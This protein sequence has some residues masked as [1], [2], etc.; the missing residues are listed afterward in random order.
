MKG[1]NRVMIVYKRKHVLQDILCMYMIQHL[2][3]AHAKRKTTS[4]IT[5]CRPTF[6]IE[7]SLS[8][9]LAA[10]SD[11]FSPV[12]SSLRI[13]YSRQ[14]L[15][16]RNCAGH[17]RRRMSRGYRKATLGGT[18]NSG[19]VSPTILMSSHST[20]SEQKACEQV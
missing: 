19:I 11:W 20:Q 7:Q 15:S 8:P 12:R 17:W 3:L 1:V 5:S 13:G 9:I 10:I 2:R 16:S 18:Y 14:R 6:E 4:K